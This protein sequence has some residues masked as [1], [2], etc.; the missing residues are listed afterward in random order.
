[1]VLFV[2]G[3]EAIGKKDKPCWISGLGEGEALKCCLSSLE[4]PG[5]GFS[6]KTSRGQGGSGEQGGYGGIGSA[7]VFGGER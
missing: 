6:T 2:L 1:M 7:L 3:M 5:S 4:S